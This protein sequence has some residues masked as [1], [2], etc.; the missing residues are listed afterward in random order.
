MLITWRT[1]LLVH[2]GK[3]VSIHAM[4]CSVAEVSAAA[5]Q[6]MNPLVKVMVQPGS[7]SV[8]DMSFLDSYQVL[9]V[10]VLPLPLRVLMLSSF[11]QY[12]VDLIVH[13]WHHVLYKTHVWLSITASLLPFL[14]S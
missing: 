8:T 4:Q 3:L 13:H 14:S 2:L 5:L 6:E 7:L 11:G 9:A 10:A 12:G 1:R